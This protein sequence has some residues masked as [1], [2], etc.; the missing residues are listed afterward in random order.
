M[1]E[2]LRSEQG[3]FQQAI[4][5]FLTTLLHFSFACFQLK[6]MNILYSYIICIYI[7]ILICNI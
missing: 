7:Y 2:D 6:Y 1:G 5:F 4:V 3:V